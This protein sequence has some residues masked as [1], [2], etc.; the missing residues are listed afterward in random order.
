MKKYRHR[1]EPKEIL[2]RRDSTLIIA[3]HNIL[4]IVVGDSWKFHNYTVLF[5]FFSNNL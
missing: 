1:T 5:K 2:F 3:K 4:S